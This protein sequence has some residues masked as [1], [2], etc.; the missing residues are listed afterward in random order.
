[1]KIAILHVLKGKQLQKNIEGLLSGPSRGYYLVQAGC[2]LKTQ[3][4]TK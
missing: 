4:W 3:T 1:M 2:I